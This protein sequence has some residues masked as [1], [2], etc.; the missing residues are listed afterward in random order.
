MLKLKLRWKFFLFLLVFSLVP[1]LVVTLISQRGTRRLGRTISADLRKNLT[2]L[3]SEALQQSAEN[4]SKTLLH[5]MNSLEF[6]LMVLANE[7]ERAL[8]EDPPPVSKVYYASDYDNPSSV[9]DDFTTVRRYRKRSP[10]GGFVPVSVSFDHPVFYLIPG[11]SEKSVAN[12][13]ARLT[14]VIPTLKNLSGKLGKIVYWTYVSTESGI[15]ISYPGHGGYPKDYD[16]RK[17]PWYYNATDDI[18]WTYPIV[19]ATSGQV[20][21]TLS[22]QIRHSNQSAIGVAAM[23][24]LITELLQERDLIYNWSSQMRSFLVATVD[25]PDS[26]ATGLLILA[27]KDYQNKE[28]PW[29]GII[30]KEWLTSGDSNKFSKMVKDLNDGES[31]CIELS[32]KDN[33]SIWSY[34]SVTGQVHFVIIVPKSVAMELP[35][36]TSLTVLDYT[37]DQLILTAIAAMI[38]I[39]FLTAAA[40]LG[41]RTITRSLLQIATAAKR[42]SGG[43]FSVRLNVR[44]GD[45]RDQVIQAVNEMGPKLQDHLRIYNSLQL[46]KEVQRRLLPHQK[47]DIAGLDVAGTSIY[48]DETG[49]DY[50]DYLLENNHATGRA[51]LVV[52]DISGH[53][54]PS[55][56]QMASARALLRQRTSLSGNIG[57]IITDVNYQ[58]TIDM[59]DSGSFMT[60]FYL[61]IDTQSR[62]IKWVRAGHDPAIFYDPVADT[63]EGLGGKGI[64]L[65]ADETWIYEENEKA[66]LRN[67]QVILIGT[68]GIWEATNSEGQ[69]FGK[70]RIY[71]MIRKNAGAGAD[72]I[73]NAVI[74]SL[75]QFRGDATPEDDVTL[76]VIKVQN[77][78]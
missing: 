31:G 17:R 27:Q 64:V 77:D 56:L 16:P 78:R 11:V 41:S 25:N 6:S 4:S 5:T 53:G 37:R 68:D 51:V 3:T 8:R 28:I 22:K 66:D 67:G 2:V 63:F 49:G 69:M 7:A 61:W 39:A 24:I 57:N 70:D 65:G 14:R 55:A 12:D 74:S 75:N 52:G 30:E 36:Q 18:R 13:I 73:M 58:L 62:K 54:L 72:E 32:Y 10:E 20:I 46:A 42:L 59:A 71:E 48:C 43:D 45:E 40:L 9:P 35:E 44:T 26:K 19:D 21:F 15:H 23:D 38:V 76:M 34:A 33:D 60:L 1:L 29:S 47:P 50:Y